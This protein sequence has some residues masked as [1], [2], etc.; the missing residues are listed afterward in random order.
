MLVDRLGVFLCS[1]ID[2][3]AL[4]SLGLDRLALC[5][6]LGLHVRASGVALARGLGGEFLI[7]LLSACG[8]F[9]GR[10]L[11]VHLDAPFGAFDLG[12]VGEGL[13]PCRLGFGLGLG[14]ARL[15]AL[16][17]LCLLK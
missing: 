14:A 2:F 5:L 12:L 15:A 17:G 10:R 8:T 9:G 13:G 7:H 4:L 3:S 1:R 6:G 11:G 16:L